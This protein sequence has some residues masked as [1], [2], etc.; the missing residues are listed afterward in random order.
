MARAKIRKAG[1]SRDRAH[2]RLRI[3]PRSF[4][5]ALGGVQAARLTADGP[6]DSA[7]RNSTERGRDRGSRRGRRLR[8]RGVRPGPTGGTQSP[9]LPLWGTPRAPNRPSV[10]HRRRCAP[11]GSTSGE[12]RAR[13]V[14]RRGTR[15]RR[16]VD[17]GTVAQHPSER[18]EICRD[19]SEG[20]RRES[21][22]R[23]SRVAHAARTRM[24]RGDG[25]RGDPGAHG[26]GPWTLD[27]WQ[28][29]RPRMR[30]FRDSGWA[31]HEYV[32]RIW[33]AWTGA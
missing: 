14:H 19:P 17:R 29:I 6:R 4:E 13:R 1:H 11:A 15:G 2:A 18:G 31:I 5:Y 22:T 25:P 7:W 26:R 12:S 32:G 28:A 20:R 16:P 30:A 27:A 10:A 23:H 33:Y 3:E 24:F 21:R 9:A 8:S